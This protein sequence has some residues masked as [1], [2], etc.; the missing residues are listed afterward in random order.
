MITKIL[1]CGAS[2]TGKTTVLNEFKKHGWDVQT[3][4]VRTLMKEKGIKI[5]ELATEEGQAMIMETISKQIG[6]NDYFVADRCWF[7]ALAYTKWSSDHGK[8]SKQ[9][10]EDQYAEGILA[11]TND[12][13]KTLIVYFPI[14][15]PLV[16]DGVRSEDENYRKEV[17]ENIKKLL[18]PWPHITVHGSVEERVFQIVNEVMWN[19]N[20]FKALDWLQDAKDMYYH[21]GIKASRNR[22]ENE[23]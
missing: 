12:M 20:G 15:F 19:H 3:E 23:K 8:F 13:D 11:F 6:E 17:D 9:F 4:V 7:D 5:N 16:K 22:K 2:G 10:Y 1:L 21:Y 14:E 18:D